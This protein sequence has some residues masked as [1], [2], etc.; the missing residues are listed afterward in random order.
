MEINHSGYRASDFYNAEV[1]DALNKRLEGYSTDYA[2]LRRQAEAEYSPTYQAEVDA[3]NERLKGQTLSAQNERQALDRAYERQRR[4]ANETYDRGAA[5]LNNA[6]TARGL[7]RSSLV[8]TQGAYLEGQRGQ[9]L[10]DISRAEADD[11]AAINSRIAQLTEETAR[12]RQSLAANY[13]QQLDNRI[14]QLRSSNQSAA[15][16]LQLQIAALQQQGYQAYQDWLLKERAQALSE[17]AFREQYGLNEDGSRRASSSSGASGKAKSTPT[18]AAK[19]TGSA[20]TLSGLIKSA[21]SGIQSALSKAAGAAKSA[22]SQT[23]GSKTSGSSGASTP[24]SGT[25]TKSIKSKA[26]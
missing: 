25:V 8:A 20:T 21:V 11:I 5:S 2:T 4:Q 12:S 6:L 19:K 14:N 10:A 13:A 18:A 22:R 1:M 26:L 7:G 3:L 17:A 23:S 16:S 9:A 15:V 24:L